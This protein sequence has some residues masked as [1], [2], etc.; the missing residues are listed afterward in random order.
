MAAAPLL[1]GAYLDVDSLLRRV[2]GLGDGRPDGAVEAVEADR[3]QKRAAARRQAPS[4]AVEQN[5]ES[6]RST[7]C[8]T[9]PADRATPIASVTSPAAPRAEPA[10]PPRNRVAATTGVQIVA[11]SGDSPRSN[12][13]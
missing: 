7:I 1:P 9:A 2:Y 10:F 5:A 13:R 4:T 12:T 3:D 8:P 6:A 11:T